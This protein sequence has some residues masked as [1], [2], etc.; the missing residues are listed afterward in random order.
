[1]NHKMGVEVEEQRMTSEKNKVI[2][3]EQTGTNE[4]K[5]EVSFK[6]QILLRKCPNSPD[7]QLLR[8]QSHLE[9]VYFILKYLC[10]YFLMC[11]SLWFSD[12]D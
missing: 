9:R 8:K 10:V 12:S 6:K 7:S 2:R 11:L 4:S 1:M 3:K 5:K